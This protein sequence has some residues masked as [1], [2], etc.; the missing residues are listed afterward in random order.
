MS[1]K[2]VMW[3][4]AAL[5]LTASAGQTQTQGFAG[6]GSDAKGFAIPH[7]GSALSFPVDHGA[8]PDY[9]IEWWYVT[10]NLQ[11]EDGKHY[12]AQ[13]TL[14]RS[15]LAPGVNQGFADPQIWI[16]H[17]AITTDDHHYV[18]E[19]LGRGGVGQADVVAS[20]FEA[21]IDDWRLAA[22]N[23]TARDQLNDLAVTANG[24]DFNYSLNLKATGPLVLQGDRGFSVKSA[25]GQASYY[26][27]QPFYR[28]SG[29][30]NVA[31]S[32]VQVSGKAWLDREW[33]SQP[34]AENQTGWDWFSLHFDTGDK[35]MAFR[36]RDDTDGFISANWISADGK[37]TPISKEDI[38]LDPIRQAKVE[39]REMPVGWRIQIPARSIDITTQALNDQSW[40]R[41]STPYW[42]GPIWFNGTA[43]GIGYLEM[44]GY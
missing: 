14:F 36:L 33:S 5:L 8:H 19:R 30:I 21:W 4:F 2:M 35:L 13:W 39:G 15:A 17:A 26:Y 1:A 20:P 23:K 31:G 25:S 41:T 44:T 28:V 22:V 6:L 7:T 3:I 42:E 40:M 34:L 38:R 32:D 11:D 9:R 10:A 37:T 16:G 29:T 27:S 18:A 12:G 24:G 43:T